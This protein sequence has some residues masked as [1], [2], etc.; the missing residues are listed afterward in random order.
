MNK[1][2]LLNWLTE[3]QQ[4]WDLILAAIGETRMNQAG[5][6]GTGDWTMGNLIAH[7]STWQ[8]WLLGRLQAAVN[9]LPEPSPPW[10]KDLTSEDDINAWIYE[11]SRGRPI[12]HILDEVKETHQQSL[13]VIRDLPDEYSIETIDGKFHPVRV[14]DQ[15]YA[16]GEFFH[17]FYDDHAPDV[18]AWLERTQGW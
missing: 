16:V 2:E 12:R 8:R 7:L 4:K 14:N 18:H 10:P 3:E 5:V 13:A 11:T 6:N 9:D 17:H 1:H 15:Y